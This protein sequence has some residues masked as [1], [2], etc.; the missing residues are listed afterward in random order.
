MTHT[1]DRALWQ[2]YIDGAA[3]GNPG[4]AGIG[5]YIEKA[6]HPYWS[7]GYA[8]DTCT[9]NQAE[10]C[11][12]LAGLYYITTHAEPHERVAIYTDSQLL[13]RH[14]H[15]VYRVK[16]KQLK[17]LYHRAMTLLSHIPQYTIVHISRS[18]NTKADRLANNG[19]DGHVQPPAYVRY[20]C[21]W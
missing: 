15:G 16:D 12:L 14:I 21:Q 2:M 10:Y 17:T 13:V 5:V 20:I 9:N 4:P 8:I 6:G 7:M 18:E 11:A 3:R 19:I 1:Y